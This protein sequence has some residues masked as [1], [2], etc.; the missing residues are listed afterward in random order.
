MWHGPAIAWPIALNTP[1]RPST[2]CILSPMPSTTGSTGTPPIP[3]TKTC[4]CMAKRS[5]VADMGPPMTTELPS[6]RTD[7]VTSKAEPTVMA[8]SLSAES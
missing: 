1:M 8:T 3:I 6:P 4:R 7:K 5:S 2:H